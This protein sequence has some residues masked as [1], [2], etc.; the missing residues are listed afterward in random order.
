MS[1]P[2]GAPTQDS[3]TQV[4]SE[5]NHLNHRGDRWHLLTM[6]TY[7][8]YFVLV[9]GIP[10]LPA[11]G[12][13]FLLFLAPRRAR[14]NPCPHLFFSSFRVPV[15]FRLLLAAAVVRFFHL[16]RACLWPSLK[17]GLLRGCRHLSPWYIP[18]TRY[19]VAFLL[20][21]IEEYYLLLL[22]TSSLVLFIVHVDVGLVRMC[23][24]VVGVSHITYDIHPD[25]T[26]LIRKQRTLYY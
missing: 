16:S 23:P 4:E 21:I 24:V 12:T 13:F 5:V 22:C 9:P 18:G 7:M 26:L 10:T 2:P 17:C 14:G 8:L 11:P 15:R 25:T 1:D 20:L 19:P 6:L 3:N